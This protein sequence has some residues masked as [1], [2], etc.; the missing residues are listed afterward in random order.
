M[1]LFKATLDTIE[2][3]HPR[4]VGRCLVECL[5]SWLERCDKVDEKGLPTL[6]R[7]AD[8]L[9]EIGDKATAEELRKES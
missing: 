6:S 3:N 1:G 5:T 4:D 9:E 2:A 7:L 8:A